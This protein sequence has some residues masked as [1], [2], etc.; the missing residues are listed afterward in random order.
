MSGDLDSLTVAWAGLAFSAGQAEPNFW[1]SRI[2]K[3][4]DDRRWFAPYHSIF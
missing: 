3:L 1:I 2:R 4:F